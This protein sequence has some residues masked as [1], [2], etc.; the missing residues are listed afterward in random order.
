MI[1]SHWFNI[2]INDPCNVADCSLRKFSDDTKLGGVADAAFGCAA[3]QRDFSRLEKRAERNFL[4]LKKVKCR[5]LHLGMNTS[6]HQ[7]MLGL[8]SSLAEKDLRVLVDTKLNVS[9]Q[10]ALATKVA[11]C[12]RRSVASK[13]EK[14]DSLAL[15]RPHLVST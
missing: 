14:S 7:S 10:C 13:V 2:F 15:V 12:I 3:I 6:M 5:V 4:K 9:Q 11:S 8:E 1:D